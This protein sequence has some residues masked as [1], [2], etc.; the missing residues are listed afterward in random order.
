MSRCTS[1]GIAA[2]LAFAADAG[3]QEKYPGIGRTATPAE[4]AAWDIDVRPDFKGLPPGSGSVAMGQTVWEAKCAS[5]HGTFGESNEVFMPIVGGTTAQD[6]Q[7]G[8]VAALM[9]PEVGR[10]TIMKLSTL[11]TLWDYINRAMPWNAPKTLTTQEVYA[12]AAY[13]LNLADIVGDDFV[14]S[15]E[16]IGEVQKR[17]PNRNGMR[18]DHGLWEVRGRP[19]VSNTPCM[20]ECNTEARL[21]SALPE[22]ARDTH[23]NLGDQNRPVGPVRGS[24]STAGEAGEKLATVTVANVADLARR[25]ACFSCHGVEKR[26][27]GPTFHEIATK[28]RGDASAEPRLAEKVR[29][30]GSGTWGTLEMPAHHDLPDADLRSLVKWILG[31]AR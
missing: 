3:A 4:I 31:G 26:I 13:I 24:Q 19:D 7:T 8:R 20:R 29:L 17:L 15:S 9:N 12:V 22:S 25:K 5:C 27:V 30:G 14:L 1:L 11:S 28:Y 21:S 18:R 16:N 2:L 23:G 10:T 6:I